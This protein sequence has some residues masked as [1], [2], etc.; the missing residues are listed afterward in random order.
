MANRDI[1][2]TSKT[3]LP[4]EIFSRRQSKRDR[5]TDMDGDAGKSADNA[6][7]KQGQAQMGIFKHGVRHQATTDE[8][9]KHLPISGKSGRLLAQYNKRAKKQISK[10]TFP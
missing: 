6:N 8:L 3:K 4:P 5:N 2:Q 1:I 10:F 9:H 7:Q